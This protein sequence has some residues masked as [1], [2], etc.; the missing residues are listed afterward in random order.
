MKEKSLLCGWWAMPKQIWWISQRQAR[1]Q[2]WICGCKWHW[3]ISW[4]L[5]YRFL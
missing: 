4:F 5:A 1:C 2:R 3:S